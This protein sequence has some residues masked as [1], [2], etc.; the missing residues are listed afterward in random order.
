MSVNFK[1]NITALY[2][3]VSASHVYINAMNYGYIEP[4]KFCKYSISILSENS[5]F[6]ESMLRLFIILQRCMAV[7]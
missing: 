4:M 6:I 5:L 2:V 7:I 3:A 1:R